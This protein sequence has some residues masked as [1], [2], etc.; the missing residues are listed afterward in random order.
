MN[1]DQIRKNVVDKLVWDGRV[2]ASDIRV[3][4]SDGQVTIFGNVPNYTAKRAVWDQAWSTPGVVSVND[5]IRVI[6]PP[7]KLPILN[8]ETLQ[9]NVETILTLNSGV[10]AKKIDVRTDDGKVEMEG[11]VDSYWKK[12]KAENLVEDIAGVTKVVNKLF[13][14]PD[15]DYEDKNIAEDLMKIYD[16]SVYVNS[17]NIDVKVENGVVT[18]SGD[19]SSWEAKRTAYNLAQLASGVQDVIDHTNVR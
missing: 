2:E 7:T 18:L 4:V 6:H 9:K 1:D 3:E 12:V 17:E 10:D 8:D 14:I 16:K 5:Q 11:A 13:V 19:L 15:G